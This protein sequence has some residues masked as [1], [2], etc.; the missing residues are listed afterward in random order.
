MK[1]SFLVV[2]LAVVSFFFAL[3]SVKAQT[4]VITAHL[5]Y[6]RECPHCEAEL[7]WFD[8]YLAQNP[9]VRLVK[10]EVWH[11]SVNQDR[12]LAATAAMGQE[13]SGI[14]YLII[15]KET[16]VGYTSDKGTGVQIEALIDFYRGHAYTDLISSVLALPPPDVNSPPVGEIVGEEMGGRSDRIA[17][18]AAM[19]DDYTPTFSVPFLENIDPRSVSLP[20]ISIII[21]AVDGFNPCAMWILIF[22]I[23]MLFGMEDR[24]KM[25][26][27]GFT[28]L[29]TSA[30]V[31]LLFMISWL[32]I[33]IFV[34]QISYIRMAIGLTAV[35]FGAVNV[36]RYYKTR[37]EAAACDVVD[38]KK[39]R[40]IMDKI[41]WITT[42]KKFILALLGIM[43]LAVGVN[44]IELLCSLGL[45]VV[46]T[47]ILSFNQLSPLAYGFYLFL[48]IFFF[49]IDDLLVFV[50]AMK[51]LAITPISSKYAKYSHLI[52]GVIMLAI[53]LLMLIKPQWLMFNF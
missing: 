21:G 28:F 43:A 4:S 24:K 10:Y 22:L 52:G 31:Y 41:R 51:T 48:Y 25:W 37:N 38:G 13:P 15:G 12:L 29:G 19:I 44:V 16:I 5:F 8:T 39:R 20:L 34:N 50:I 18:M 49:L 35:I 46:F 9:D 53:G 42:E 32:N 36:W 7:K 6:G 2:G 14:P 33:A 3:V 45:P 47:Q 11:D 1:R 26:I 23:T 17:S 27:L 40:K 30:F